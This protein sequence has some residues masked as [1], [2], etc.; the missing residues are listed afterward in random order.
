MRELEQYI[1][2]ND[3]QNHEKLTYKHIRNIGG[4]AGGKVDLY[5]GSDGEYYAMK[6]IP[7]HLI[8]DD[9]TETEVQLL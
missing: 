9:N 3:L 1:E 5:K 7:L 4:G 2:N 6:S 8:S